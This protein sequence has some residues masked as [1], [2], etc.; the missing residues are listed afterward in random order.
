MEIYSGPLTVL[1]RK[2]RYAPYAITAM[3]FGI[4]S[5][6]A[7]CYFG[8]VAAIVALVLYRKGMAAYRQNPQ[9]FKQQSL[10]M[11]NTARVCGIIGLVVSLVTLVLYIL[12]I[13]FIVGMVTS[14]AH[15]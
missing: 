13:C 2:P 11:L 5:I 8:W 10:G 14:H 9:I 15:Y 6:A 4:V 3:I 12:Y 7:M 1:P